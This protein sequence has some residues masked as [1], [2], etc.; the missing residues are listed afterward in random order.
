V[1]GLQNNVVNILKIVFNVFTLTV[2]GLK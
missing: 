2:R 1:Y